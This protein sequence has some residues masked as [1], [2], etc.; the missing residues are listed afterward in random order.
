[1]VWLLDFRSPLKSGPFATQPHFN[2]SKSRLVRISDLHFNVIS[3][4]Y[5]QYGNLYTPFK[6]SLGLSFSFFLP[7]LYKLSHSHLNSA[8]FSCRIFASWAWSTRRPT[9]RSPP[10][11]STSCIIVWRRSDVTSPLQAPDCR[12]TCL[13]GH[14]SQNWMRRTWLLK[15]I[16]IR[17]QPT[18]GWLRLQWP[19]LISIIGNPRKVKTRQQIWKKTYTTW[20]CRSTESTKCLRGRRSDK[21]LVYPFY[22]LI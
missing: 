5:E 15:L 18:T 22:L 11:T 6:A 9:C 1:M 4:N 14:P 10:S 2:H 16:R 12:Q 21:C 13:D 17:G 19:R 20:N 8:H 3:L 7:T